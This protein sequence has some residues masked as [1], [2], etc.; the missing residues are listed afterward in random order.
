MNIRE[1]M[2]IEINELYKKLVGATGENKVEL[3]IKIDEMEVAL[4][5]IYVEGDQLV[6]V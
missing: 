6:A 4:E 1:Q 3:M 5:S 2:M